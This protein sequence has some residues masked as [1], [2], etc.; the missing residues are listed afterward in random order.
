MELFDESDV[1]MV[2]DLHLQVADRAETCL[3]QDG[4]CGDGS[5]SSKATQRAGEV[6][7]CSVAVRLFT[8]QRQTV[9][10][11]H[12]RSGPCGVVHGSPR[13]KHFDVEL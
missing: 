13:T 3:L 9:T 1:S 12:D 7:G 11:I 6:K 10:A 2:V 5:F 4:H 8:E